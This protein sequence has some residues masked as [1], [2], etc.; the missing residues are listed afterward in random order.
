MEQVV[1]YPPSTTRMDEWPYVYIYTMSSDAMT[2]DPFLCRS[3]KFLERDEWNVVKT[4]ETPLCLAGFQG[5]EAY[6]G[7]PL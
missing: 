4:H 7:S 2:R 5:D 1:Y 6:R 3:S